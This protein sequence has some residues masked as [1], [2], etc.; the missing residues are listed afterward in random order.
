[1]RSGVAFSDIIV[2][3]GLVSKDSF[4]IHT[5]FLIL[6]H[7]SFLILAHNCFLIS[8]FIILYS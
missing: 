3:G 8:S 5:S 7:P 4:A 1:M 2:A 6:V